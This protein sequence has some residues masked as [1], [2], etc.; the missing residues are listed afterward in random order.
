MNASDLSCEISSY[1]INHCFQCRW[2]KLRPPYEWHSPHQKRRHLL[3]ELSSK[4]SS[5]A[6]QHRYG[7]A[8]NCV[9]KGT[10]SIMGCYCKWQKLFLIRLFHILPTRKS[11]RNTVKEGC[12]E[13]F[14]HDMTQFELRSLKLLSY[15]HK[16]TLVSSIEAREKIASSAIRSFVC[17]E[18]QEFNDNQIMHA[19]QSRKRALF[20]LPKVS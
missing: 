12:E 1:S 20:S 4:S 16:I 13:A 18:G 14:R 8:R 19:W 11:L 6:D 3:L 15:L 7:T 9:E 5:Q 10:V 2:Y 17:N